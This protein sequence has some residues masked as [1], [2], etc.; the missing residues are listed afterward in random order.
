MS[1]STFEA[2]FEQAQK[3]S[4]VDRLRL[5]ERLSMTLQA[6]FIKQADWHAALRSTY[7][8]LADDPIERPP[9]PPLEEREIIA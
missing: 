3:L 7:G 8:I 6:D 1:E 9:Q 5:M 4:P 2:L